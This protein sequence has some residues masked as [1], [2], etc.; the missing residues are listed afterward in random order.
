MP[1]RLRHL[2]ELVSE[3]LEHLDRTRSRS[4][5]QER[6]RH[7]RDDRCSACGKRGRDTGGSPRERSREDGYR[8]RHEQEGHPYD[9]TSPAYGVR[10][11]LVYGEPGSP[12]ERSRERGNG[13]VRWQHPRSPRERSRENGYGRQQHPGSPR[14][15][16]REGKYGRQR[17]RSP[18][19]RVRGGGRYKQRSESSRERSR[20]EEYGEPEQQVGSLRSERSRVHGGNRQ[21]RRHWKHR[22][23]GGAHQESD[24]MAAAGAGPS[25]QERE[26]EDPRPEDIVVPSMTFE[27]TRPSMIESLQVT[28]QKGQP[29]TVVRDDA[30]AECEESATSAGA[31]RRKIVSQCTIGDCTFVGDFHKTHFVQEHLPS[32][33]QPEE[34]DRHSSSQ[35]FQE[36]RKQALEHLRILLECDSLHS[37]VDLALQRVDLTRSTFPAQMLT[38]MQGFSQYMGW[39]IPSSESE[40]AVTSTPAI[41]AHTGATDP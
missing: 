12:R 41:L 32:V 9:E 1:R 23:R 29:R 39:E 37:L 34:A 22:N 30:T 14:E 19:E 13:G 26:Q 27:S 6:A 10:G 20:E 38:N 33:H 36:K 31:R 21:A 4:R 8:R 18:R 7:P 15:R 3:L 35:E 40:Q 2:T 11:S 17:S 24:R 28:M 25:M 5:S 16:S